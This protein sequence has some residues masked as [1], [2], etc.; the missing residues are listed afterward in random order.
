MNTVTEWFQRGVAR[1]N[2]GDAFEA[3]NCYG[4][5][6]ALGGKTFEVY[7]NLAFAMQAIGKED[8]ALANYTEAARLNPGFAEAQN[9]LG[10]IFLKR[11]RLE[12]EQNFF[13]CAFSIHP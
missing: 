13:E 12:E 5:V 10:N 8:E 11:E 4:R 3:I 6:I 9:N 2:A 1:Q 7:Y